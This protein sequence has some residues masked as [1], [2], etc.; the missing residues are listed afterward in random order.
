M[1][2][3]WTGHDIAQ[4]PGSR[5]DGG[6]R[7][8]LGGD[9]QQLDFEHVAGLGAFDEDR[10]RQGMHH[11]PIDTCKSCRGR[12]RS[13][14]PVE[15]I[16]GFQCDLFTLANLQHRLYVRMISI[17]SAV[18]FLCERLPSID[19]DRVHDKRSWICLPGESN[20]IR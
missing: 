19:L 14:L 4:E 6:E 10:S 7:S 9:V 1:D 5:Q 18:R 11:S 16:P 15:R 20:L 12:G 17:V 2:K 3:E 8:W 13:D